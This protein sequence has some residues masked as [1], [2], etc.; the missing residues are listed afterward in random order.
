MSLPKKTTVIEM[1]FNLKSN[2]KNIILRTNIFI[3]SGIGIS[4]IAKY[5]RNTLNIGLTITLL[6]L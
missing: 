1:T 6:H 5:Q 2:I 3:F 4:E